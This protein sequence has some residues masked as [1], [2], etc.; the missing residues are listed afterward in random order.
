MPEGDV[1]W[2]K[3]NKKQ[4]P[5]RCF[6]KNA[7]WERHI[8]YYISCTYICGT[9]T[10]ALIS[11]TRTLS[12]FANLFLLH[13]IPLISPIGGLHTSS[14]GSTMSGMHGCWMTSWKSGTIPTRRRDVFL[15]SAIFCH[16][17]VE[18]LCIFNVKIHRIIR[19]SCLLDAIFGQLNHPTPNCKVA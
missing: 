11:S 8:L 2:E 12:Y 3:P 9:R 15:F 16:S 5:K 13:K 1:G 18:F 14:P 17:G 4:W 6:G 10:Y 7:F 19:Q